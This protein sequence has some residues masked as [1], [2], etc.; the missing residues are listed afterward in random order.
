[1]KKTY[2]LLL[3]LFPIH[4]FASNENHLAGARSHAMG[5]S[6]VALLDVWAGFHNQAIL[7]KLDKI[8]FGAYYENRFEV[9]ELSTKAFHF[10]YPTSLGTFSMTYKQFGFNLYKESKI[11]IAY[12]RALGKHF[13]AGLQFD[14]I[15]KELNQ[16]FGSQNKYTFEAGI[17][18][19]IFPDIQLGFHIFN[20]SQTN[21]TTVDYDDKIACIARLG[22]SW[23][24]SDQTIITS[25]IEKNLD[26]DTRTKF[27]IEYGISETISLRAGVYNHPNTISLGMG[28]SFKMLKANISFSRH[29]VLGYTPSAAINIIF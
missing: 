25:E 8:S 26:Y 16:S 15:K 5:N 20:P 23:K 9:K 6:S 13:W 14:Q 21:F 17:L 28:F 19:E 18:A 27:G 29:P 1:M 11:G 3:I 12:S 4:L 10:N 7:A 24:L 22:L 2:L